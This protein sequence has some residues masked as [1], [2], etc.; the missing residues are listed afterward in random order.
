MAELKALEPGAAA[1]PALKPEADVKLFVSYDF[2]AVDNPHI[3]RAG[4][5]GIN[6][7]TCRALRGW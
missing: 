4:L 6:Q 5:Y 2:Y 1:D 7:G 3:H